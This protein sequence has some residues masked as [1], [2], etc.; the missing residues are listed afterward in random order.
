MGE[1][2]FSYKEKNL[3]TGVK[4]TYEYKV[5]GTNGE[6]IANVSVLPFTFNS[7]NYYRSGLYLVLGTNSLEVGMFVIA[8]SGSASIQIWEYKN[9]TKNRQ[10]SSLSTDNGEGLHSGMANSTYK[11]TWRQTKS[12]AEFTNIYVNP[13][14]GYFD[15]NSDYVEYIT[16]AGASV[17]VNYSMPQDETFSYVKLV[18]KKGSI[19]TSVD[20]G[21]A[22]DLDTSATSVTVTGLDNTKGTKYYFVIYTDR[23]VSDEVMYEMGDDPV[24]WINA[25]LPNTFP[26]GI[27]TKKSYWL[28][29]PPGDY[30]SIPSGLNVTWLPASFY[31]QEDYW[32]FGDSNWGIKYTYESDSSGFLIM[33]HTYMNGLQDVRLL[34]ESYSQSAGWTFNDLLEGKIK[35]GFFCGYNDANGI[36]SIFFLKQLV[37]TSYTTY[38]VTQAYTAST[39]GI[40]E[41]VYNFLTYQPT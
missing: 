38:K 1:T 31:K 13:K 22:I 3:N 26:T 29:I 36:G 24:V 40:K 19:P 14:F 7:V 5:E 27:C 28:N 18:Y 10:V 9:G 33:V 32:V 35:Y 25:T 37:G 39:T 15:N 6:L 8:T 30:Y 23:T 12:G 34:Y 20:D 17:K 4:T 21:T 2:L 11:T 41:K 16:Y